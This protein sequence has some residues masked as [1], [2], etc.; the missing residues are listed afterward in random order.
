[1]KFEG[2]RIVIESKEEAEIVASAAEL[3]SVDDLPSFYRVIDKDRIPYKMGHFTSMD[4]LNGL[5]LVIKNDLEVSEY[6]NPEIAGEYLV[7]LDQI[8]RV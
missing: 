6:L 7:E 2:E 4:V 5:K 8:L 3:V 1:M